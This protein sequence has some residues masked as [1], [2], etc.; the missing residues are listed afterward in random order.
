[1]LVSIV[2]MRGVLAAVR[3]CLSRVT[4]GSLPSEGTESDRD[5]V[6]ERLIDGERVW[7]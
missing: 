2:G 3:C 6:K 5:M 7:L 4:Q 1:M